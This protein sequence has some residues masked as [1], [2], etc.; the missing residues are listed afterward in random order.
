MSSAKER[1]YQQLASKLQTVSREL[2]VTQANFAELAK[3]LQSM[4]KLGA[5]QASQFMAV[6][7]LLDAEMAAAEEAAG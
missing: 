1:H 6:S 5:I 4:N 2:Q 7:R 3:Q